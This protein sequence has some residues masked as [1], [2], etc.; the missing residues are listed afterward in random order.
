MLDF[1]KLG[2]VVWAAHFTPAT[3]QHVLTIGG[4][5]AALWNLDT[6]RPVDAV[7]PARRRRLRRPLA[8]RQAA[9]DRQ[10]GPLGQDLGRRHR[11]RHP[12]AR[13][14]PHRLH[15]H[16]RVL[17]RRPASC[18]PPATTAPPGCGT[19]PPASRP[20]SSFT[21]HTDRVLARDVLARRRARAHRQRRQDGP[22]LGPPDGPAPANARPATIGP[23]SAASSRRT[24]GSSSPAARTRPP[25][26][27]TPPPANSSS[28]SPATRPPSPRSPSRPTRRRVLTG[29]QDNTVKLWDA[30]T[31]CERGKEILSL[32]GH[33]QE[34]T[35]VSFSPD[36]R[37]RPHLEP[38]RHRHHLARRRL[39]QRRR[40]PH[41]D[42]PVACTAI[43]AAVVAAIGHYF[44]QHFSSP[45]RPTS[46]SAQSLPDTEGGCV[47]A[48]R[49]VFAR[50]ARS[51]TRLLPRKARSRWP[52][53]DNFP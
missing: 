6:L 25:S 5:D 1:H 30:R 31:D 22:H 53:H 51:S 46:R 2:G 17:A 52:Q 16:G 32:A 8:G 26:S 27:G 39:A 41:R 19:S 21:G 44:W 40:A 3:A 29:S 7:Q 48:R 28:S 23:C 43:T 12:Q 42:E 35:S 13:R 10:L 14:R 24:A 15:Q 18:S 50:R 38:R 47:C 45:P 4:N 11:P 37:L 34:V 36:G 20:R 49:I 33:T 9:R